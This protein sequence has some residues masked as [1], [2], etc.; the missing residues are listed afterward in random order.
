L[1]AIRRV[2]GQ[3]RGHL[4]VF[5]DLRDGAGKKLLLKVSNDLSINP[6]N[7]N[8]AELEFILGKGHVEFSRQGNGM[9]RA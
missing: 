1:E 3:A 8:K 2:L 6:T 9:S 4:P 5:L 7:L